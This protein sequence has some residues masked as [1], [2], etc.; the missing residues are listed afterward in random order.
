[1]TCPEFRTLCQNF[2]E[3]TRAQRGAGLTHYQTCHECAVWLQTHPEGMD[4]VQRVSERNALEREARL[5]ARMD[6]KDEEY[7]P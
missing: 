7:H 1:M 4:S 5:L 6:S 3:S 2:S